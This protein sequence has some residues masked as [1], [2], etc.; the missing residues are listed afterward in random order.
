MQHAHAHNTH[1]VS[2]RF[3]PSPEVLVVVNQYSKPTIIINP[4]HSPSSYENISLLFALFQRREDGAAGG[5]SIV[6]LLASTAVC[7]KY[8]DLLLCYTRVSVVPHGQRRRAHQPL[9]AAKLAEHRVVT[10]GCQIGYMDHTGCHHL[11]SSTIRPT[12]VVTPGGCQIGY[13]DRT[14]CH[15]LLS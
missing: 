10:P 3:H 6:A 5:T 7:L 9:L 14:G 2:P 8:L 13:M 15:Q 1:H 4:R 11:V 12:R